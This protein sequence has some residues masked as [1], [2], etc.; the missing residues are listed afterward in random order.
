MK[1]INVI[2]TFLLVEF[3]HHTQCMQTPSLINKTV[4][5]INPVTD[6]VKEPLA[7]YPFFNANQTVEER[8]QSLPIAGES[9]FTS[10]RLTQA[11][12]NETA[13]CEDE[14]EDE[15]YIKLP[16]LFYNTWTKSYGY[17]R[18]W[19]PKSAVKLYD[20]QREKQLVLTTPWYDK[21]TGMLFSAGTCFMHTGTNTTQKVFNI[22]YKN[23]YTSV[24]FTHARLLDEKQSI[25]KRIFSF[26]TLL[27]KWAYDLRTIP[28][29]WAGKSLTTTINVH[30]FDE[31]YVDTKNHLW[32]HQ[33][34]KPPFSGFDCS[35][36]IIA[37][38]QIC[39]IPYQ[40]KTTET[41]KQALAH[42]TE[43]DDI[44]PGDLIVLPGHIM[45]VSNTHAN[46]LIESVGY[47]SGYGKL[48]E[49]KLE[50][51]LK[52]IR[53][54]DQLKTCFLN[55]LPISLCDKE[56]NITQTNTFSILKMESCVDATPAS[57]MNTYAQISDKVFHKTRKLYRM[58]V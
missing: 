20:N 26:V 40:L 18:G 11:L 2:I 24:P 3:I 4:I 7:H 34:A 38:A 8:Y 56:G 25:D 35:S 53:S 57:L 58:P 48:H 43:E 50:K 5:F 39:N 23:T 29:V 13:L 28:Y 17:L 52:D 54:Y 14:T 42:L 27:Q 51:R 55:N 9:S 41:A 36:L 44:A 21:K 16:L 22:E 47:R 32:Y 12:F 46:T 37:A 6:I 30:K 19:A 15:V 45:V 33:Q 10:I 31:K 1:T 49:I